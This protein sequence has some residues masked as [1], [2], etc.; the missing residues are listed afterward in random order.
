[1]KKIDI[2][3]SYVI[4]NHIDILKIQ[5]VSQWVGGFVIRCDGLRLVLDKEYKPLGTDKLVAVIYEAENIA[6]KGR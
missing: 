4:L 5:E 2:E 3:K 1:M 6:K